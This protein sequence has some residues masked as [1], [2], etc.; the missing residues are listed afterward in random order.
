VL[1][2]FDSLG[3]V[4]LLLF[5]G[6]DGLIWF[7]I[8]SGREIGGAKLHFLNV[9]QG[10]AILLELPGGVQILT[11]AGPD[12][13]VLGELEEVFSSKDRYIDIAVISHPQLDHM[14]GLNHIAKRYGIGAVII[15]G[16][17]D[18]ASEVEWEALL[19]L[20]RK[21]NIPIVTAGRGDVIRYR[22]SRI[23][24]LAPD[25][26]WINSGELNDTGI[27]ELIH[28]PNF[29]ALLTADIGKN[30]EEYLLRAFELKADIL[31]AGHHGSKYSSSAEFLEKVKPKLTVIQAGRGNRYGHPAEETLRRL[32]SSG[33]RIL[34]T[35]L[36]GRVTVVGEGR[37]IKI[38]VERH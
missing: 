35:D 17:R 26:N 25:K 36:N 1:K 18:T 16:R 31:K 28:T 11:D 4:I 7:E 32:K 27:V 22:D 30:V 33:S 24:I 29:S 38:F 19:S 20:L 5:V 23:D 34:R 13:K 14:N 2:R 9:G 10:D 6:L 15:N 21:R 37:R 8:L 3:I 12:S